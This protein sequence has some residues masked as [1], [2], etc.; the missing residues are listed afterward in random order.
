[1]SNTLFLRKGV[2]RGKKVMDGNGIVRVPLVKFDRMGVKHEMMQKKTPE[3]VVVHVL[4]PNERRRMG[5]KLRKGK[6][7]GLMDVVG[8]VFKTHRKPSTYDP[9]RY[10]KETHTYPPPPKEGGS[11]RIGGKAATN[12]K[13]IEKA[14]SKRF[15]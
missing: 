13:A 9:E 10:Y 11:F 2:F 7:F 12:R 1:M 6:G 5:M 15:K 8:E 3:G 4:H 14:L